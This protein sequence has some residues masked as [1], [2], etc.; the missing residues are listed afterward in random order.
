VFLVR[1]HRLDHHRPA[2]V[3]PAP[4]NG[5]PARSVGG[6]NAP[7]GVARPPSSDQAASLRWRCS[8]EVSAARGRVGAA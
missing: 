2:V 3:E 8:R 5:S 4:L 6:V 7:G 1:E